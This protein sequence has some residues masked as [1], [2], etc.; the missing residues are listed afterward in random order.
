MHA[1]RHAALD[2]LHLGMRHGGLIVLMM[3]LAT[4]CGATSTPEAR[5]AQS[6]EVGAPPGGNT[7]HVATEDEL[8][9]QEVDGGT[10]T[11][12][13]DEIIV[14]GRGFLPPLLVRTGIA[15]SSDPTTARAGSSF[16]PSYCIGTFPSRPQ[17]VVK[18][19][20]RI[21]LLR[22][23]VDS[24]GNDLTL[25]VHTPDGQ[26]HCNDDSGDPGNGLNPTVEL[27]SP[28]VG[29]IEVWV[30]TYSS[31]ATGATYTVGVT[32]QPGYASDL[33]RH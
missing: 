18:L 8:A 11:L 1:D 26:W 31:Y 13:A 30:G 19:G 15:G 7:N 32:E 9:T 10:P 17:H 5:H 25:A 21:D 23:V 6:G 14:S 27:S 20:G 28:P 12:A 22:I 2:A 33:L 24:P 4:A 16:D 29:E 3:S